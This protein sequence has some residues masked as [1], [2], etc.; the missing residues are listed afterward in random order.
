[1]IEYHKGNKPG[2]MPQQRQAAGIT[3]KGGHAVDKHYKESF[4]PITLDTYNETKETSKV[5]VI[6]VKGR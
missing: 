4:P 2:K 1:M 5:K 6:S 3:G